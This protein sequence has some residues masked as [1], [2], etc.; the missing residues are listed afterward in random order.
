MFSISI[1]AVPMA[2]K[3][4]VEAERQMEL[5][6]KHVVF[7][8]TLT[9]EE[10][11]SKYYLFWATKTSA[12][13]KTLVLPGSSNSGPGNKYHFFAVYFWC[14]LC[15]P[16][17][18]FFRDIMITFGLHLLDF[19]PNAVMTM[20][21]FAH[22]CENFVGVYPSTALFRHY[23]APRV[24]KGAP[25]SGC[26]AWVTKTGMKKTYLDGELRGRWS[27]WRAEWCWIVEEDPLSFCEPRKI[28]VERGKDWGEPDPE[29]KKLGIAITRIQRLKRAGL[30]IG[31]VGVDFLR[32]CIAPL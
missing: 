19:T 11:W 27:D 29:D 24:E 28:P 10:L 23:F 32:R 6:K 26:I 2:P 25:L 20:A 12:H 21:I 8:P 13:P 5:R 18:D 3:M 1:C 22:L 15:S 4:S 30:T 16:F 14:G 31:M 7:P 9:R 17:S